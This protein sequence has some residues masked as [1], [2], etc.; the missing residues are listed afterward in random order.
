MIKQ[1]L[2]QREAKVLAFIEEKTG[3]FEDL[4]LEIHAWQRTACRPYANFCA[5]MPSPA[6]WHEIPAL[7][8]SAF[9]QAAIR[10]FSEGETERTFRTSGTTGEGYGEHHFQTLEVYRAAA[11]AGWQLAGLPAGNVHCLL[12]KPTESPHSSLSCMAGW[13]APA[14]RFFWKDW[15]PL[16]KVL[17]GTEGPVALFGTALAF[18][19]FFDWLGSRTLRLPEGSLAI[20][21]GGYKGSGREIPQEEFYARFTEKL[22]LEDI[23]N[24]YGMTELSSQFYAAGC[25]GVHRGGPWVR[26]RVID[27]ETGLEAQDGAT[28]VLRIFDLANIGSC[29]AI[30]TRDLAIR[31]GKDFELIG[32]DPA[33][34]PRGCSR[35][36]DEM[37]AR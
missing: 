36:A 29:C 27:P 15:D 32:R 20:E 34:L 19:D 18:L 1:K 7:P 14:E 6:T 9:R 21:T 23:R 35:S 26:A 13:L 3:N 11:L 30:Q 25:P 17:T 37:L 10:C 31:R 12:P 2:S 22:G 5:P 4:I 16:A 33:A 8:L 24:E 28:G